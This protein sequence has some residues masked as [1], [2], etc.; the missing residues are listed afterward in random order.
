MSDLVGWNN[1]LWCGNK[2]HPDHTHPPWHQVCLGRVLYKQG[3]FYHHSKSIFNFSPV[4]CWDEKVGLAIVFHEGLYPFHH[5][6]PSS[7]WVRCFSS[8]TWPQPGVRWYK[9]FVSRGQKEVYIFTT[10]TTAVAP[11][12]CTYVKLWTKMILPRTRGLQN[13]SDSK[14]LRSKMHTYK[15]V[16]FTNLKQASKLKCK[17]NPSTTINAF[18]V[19]KCEIANLNT[20]MRKVGGGEDDRHRWVV[21]SVQSCDKSTIVLL[22]KTVYNGSTRL[23]TS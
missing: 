2:L 12:W 22:V 11:S 17:R 6:S 23:K 14:C 19:S 9:A 4:Q 20:E 8:E 10:K 5:H 16:I 18:T 21:E 1:N 7:P 15:V 3:S 13:N